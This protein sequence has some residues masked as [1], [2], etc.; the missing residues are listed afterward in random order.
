[1]HLSAEASRSTALS[2]CRWASGGFRHR[3]NCR[4]K[5]CATG[6]ELFSFTS[7]EC[8][9]TLW[10]PPLP[11]VRFG[12]WVAPSGWAAR[13]S[14]GIRSVS[15][16]F[17]FQ[18]PLRES[19]VGWASCHAP[20]DAPFGFHP[21]RVGLLSR[22][23]RRSVQLSP[24]SGGPPVTPRKTLRSAFTLVGWASCHAPKDAPFSLHPGR[25]GL[26][27]CSEEQTVR[28]SPCRR[29]FARRPQE[30]PLGNASRS[31]AEA[32]VRFAGQPL[33]VSLSPDRLGQVTTSGPEVLRRG[34]AG[35]A[36]GVVVWPP[37]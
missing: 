17:G 32:L 37:C 9:K 12:A 4:P 25:V 6:L 3:P 27:F 24:W 20:K 36:G 19:L 34:L 31:R 23:E 13:G 33:Q 29:A 1:M 28:R 10:L 21:G 26:L 2:H 14:Q 18:R 11:F 30:A 22:L 8:P 7:R 5:P 35:W 16:P 15:S